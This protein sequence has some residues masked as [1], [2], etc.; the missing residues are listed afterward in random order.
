LR[1]YF[2]SLWS[3]KKH[4]EVVKELAECPLLVLDDL[5]KVTTYS[6]YGIR[7]VRRHRQEDDIIE[8]NNHNHEL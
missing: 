2:N 5:G 4:S 8:A 1:K 6:T 7:P 3:E